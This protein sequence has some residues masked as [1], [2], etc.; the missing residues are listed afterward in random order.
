[1]LKNNVDSRVRWGSADKISL[2]KAFLHN[3]GHADILSK[4]LKKIKQN[5][6]ICATFSKS[7]KSTWSNLMLKLK[8]NFKKSNRN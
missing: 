8:Y 3:C 7:Q 6:Q 5:K 1:M 2:F 4:Q